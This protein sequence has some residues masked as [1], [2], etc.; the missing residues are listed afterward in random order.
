MQNIA[1]KIIETFIKEKRILTIQELSL[2]ENEDLNTKKISFVTIY[3]NWKVIASSWRV[4]IK[5]WDTIQEL[6]ENSLLCLKDSRFS[7]AIKSQSEINDIQ[8]RVDIIANEQR[9]MVNNLDEININKH[10]LI[11]ISQLHWALWVI[12]P[13]IANMISNP[14][15]L[16][17][18]VCHKAWLDSKNINND[19]YIL[20]SIESTKYSDF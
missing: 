18:L 15:D 4:N 1:K 3:K 11:I 10:W 7:E 2:W 20:Y 12:L 6:I 13:N 5:K 16:F 8:I 19:E 14:Q 17:D 9:K